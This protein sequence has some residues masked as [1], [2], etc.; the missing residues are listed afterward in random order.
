MSRS[1]WSMAKT[2]S[3]DIENKAAFSPYGKI[4][5]S[6]DPYSHGLEKIYNFEV[7]NATTV[8][9]LQKVQ[10]NAQVSLEDSS[11]LEEDLVFDFGKPFLTGLPSVFLYAPIEIL[12][13]S[14]F[15]QK[16]LIHLGVHTVKEAAL[17]SSKKLE[18]YKGLHRGHIEEI[19]E[20]IG[21]LLGKNPFQKK[22]TL[23]FEALL[24]V[25]LQ[26][27][28]PK[29]RYILLQ[30]H[31]LEA[32]CTISSSDLNEAELLL[33]SAT[34][35]KIYTQ[36]IDTCRLQSKHVLLSLLEDITC[37]FIRPYLEKELGF[38]LKDEL[39]EYLMLFSTKK[40][41]KMLF[42]IIDVLQEILSSEFLLRPFLFEVESCVYAQDSKTVAAIEQI[43]DIALQYFYTHMVHYEFAEL[44][45]YIKKELVIRW[46]NFEEGFVEKVLSTLPIF[47]RFR[48][49]DEKVYIQLSL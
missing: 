10:L 7:V 24:K 45:T 33:K 35:H 4:H 41:P 9:P 26:V 23:D 37:A 49:Q 18:E 6:S 43:V 25:V 21:K 2:V 14:P 20:K 15:A 32:L 42:S 5:A 31:G 28:H 17:L 29:E 27:I 16:A 47:S 36:A 38:V 8:R 22:N 40:D 39:L 44:S 19:H 46:I 11:L 3:E 48:G 30:R 1:K 13:L 34:V 12:N